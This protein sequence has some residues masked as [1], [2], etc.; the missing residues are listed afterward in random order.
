MTDF[1]ESLLQIL[2]LIQSNINDNSKTNTDKILKAINKSRE[3]FNN[4]DNNTYIDYTLSKLRPHLKYLLEEDDFLFS[5]EYTK[6]RLKLISGLDFKLIWNHLDYEIQ[7]KIW[8]LLKKMYVFGSFQLGVGLKDPCVKK[9]L[10]QFKETQKI[11]DIVENELQAE[12]L[13]ENPQDNIMSVFTNL[14]LNSQNGESNGLDQNMENLLKLDNPL[15]KLTREIGDELTS[16]DFM[17]DLGIDKAMSEQSNPQEIMSKL[18]QGDKLQKIST[19]FL[20]MFQEKIKE[21]NLNEESLDNAAKDLASNLVGED[22]M[23]DYESNPDNFTQD[24]LLEK[25]TKNMSQEEQKQFSNISSTLFNTVDQKNLAIRKI[26]HTAWEEAKIRHLESLGGLEIDETEIDE[27]LTNKDVQDLETVS[28]ILSKDN[29]TYIL[30]G[31]AIMK[32]ESSKWQNFIDTNVNHSQAVSKFVD[33]AWI[34]SK[35]SK[36]QLV[37]N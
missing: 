7:G 8:E 35:I 27:E 29:Y 19:K 14:I 15:V 17:K 10:K 30:C 34:E 1:S 28:P 26:L 37:Q 13:E 25:L 11:S 24:K 36:L 21:S 33:H 4:T 22:H 5:N 2:H 16:M 3:K 9:I 32:I 23:G 18:F 31:S 12:E 20:N 6:D